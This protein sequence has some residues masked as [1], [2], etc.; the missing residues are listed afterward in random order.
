M[1]LL[2]HPFFDHDFIPLANCYWLLF[3][4]LVI[5]LLVADCEV[6]IDDSL[7]LPQK[8]GTNF[9]WRLALLFGLTINLELNSGKN[10][11]SRG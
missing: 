8:I 11:F 3:I 2:V 10:S 7:V 4:Q 1:N 9:L 5:M 6:I